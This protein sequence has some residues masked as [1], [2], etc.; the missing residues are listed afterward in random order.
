MA[1][2]NGRNQWLDLLRALAILLVLVSHGFT[3]I[4]EPAVVLTQHMAGFFGVEVFFCLSGFL[5]GGILIDT[6]K[7]FDG[8]MATIANFM[9]RRWFRTLP[10]YYFYLVVNLL[11]FWLGW[12]FAK[13]AEVGRYLVFAQ[14]LLSVHPSFFPEAWSLAVEEVFYFALP[15]A[16][17]LA[18]TLLRKPMLS[19]L[20]ALFALLALSMALRYHGALHATHWDDE[21]R[22]I[23]LYR[24]DSLMW[25]VLLAY[26][27]RVTLRDKPAALRILSFALLGFLPV[28][29]YAMWLDTAWLDTH[30]FAKFWLFTVTSLGVCGMITL[31]LSIQ[32]P[33]FVVAFTSRIA[34]LSYSAYLTNLSVFYVLYHYFGL[35]GTMTEKVMRIV[36][37]FV[38]VFSMSTLTYFGVER[39]FLR[40]RDK[41]VPAPQKMALRQRSQPDAAV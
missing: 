4:P 19:L 16:I 23:A 5:I 29:I 34:K 1:N 40:L 36:G 35:G 41:W 13:E 25:G 8:S 26:L 12:T 31:G 10:N 28:A 37:F 17:V 30:F 6:V 15:I 20:V 22:K 27:H 33:R 21:V 11:I 24:L 2:Y 38:I 7:Q 32:L 39:P 18:W 9:A 3:F 14:N